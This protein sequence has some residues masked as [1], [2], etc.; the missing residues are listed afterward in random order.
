MNFHHIYFGFIFIFRLLFIIYYYFKIDFLAFNA[1]YTLSTKHLVYDP[2]VSRKENTE[3][4]LVDITRLS[5]EGSIKKT[6]KVTLTNGRFYELNAPS[7][8]SFIE[9]VT[10]Q[11]KAAG[12]TTLQGPK[13]LGLPFQ[14]SMSGK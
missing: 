12:N 5:I 7:S 2:T 11:A 8:D 4:N 3:I 13:T 10:E 1:K 9:I 14:V 6:L